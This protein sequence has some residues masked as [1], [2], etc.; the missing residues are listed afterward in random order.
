M[1]S[2][3]DDKPMLSITKEIGYS[4]RGTS[5]EATTREAT[6]AK[7]RIFLGNGTYGYVYKVDMDGTD[8]AMKYFTRRKNLLH[9]NNLQELDIMCRVRNLPN[10]VHCLEISLDDPQEYVDDGKCELPPVCPLSIVMELYDY[11]MCHYVN[12]DTWNPPDL[13]DIAF[14][15]TR[16][17]CHL[18]SLGI[19]HRDIKPTN[20]FMKGSV[21]Y[22]GDFGLT[23][24]YNGVDRLSHSVSQINYRAPEM[25]LKRKYDYKIDVWALGVI[26]YFCFR[27]SRCSP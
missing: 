18:H 21:P 12:H 5:R 13:C 4:S 23:R 14:K 20:I 15:I 3:V 27:E 16:G 6:T 22:I 26:L 19:I 2:T 8:R 10:L 7:S 25:I 11:D 1:S 17:L 9:L 24:I